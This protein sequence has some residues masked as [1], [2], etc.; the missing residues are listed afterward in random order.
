MHI[1]ITSPD[2]EAKFWLE[3]KVSLAYNHGLKDRQVKEL[4]KIVEAKQNECRA[5]WKKFFIS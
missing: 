1:H 2:G 4:A 5:A 3:P